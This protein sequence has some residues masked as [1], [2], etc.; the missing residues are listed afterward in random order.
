MPEIRLAGP[1]DFEGW[2]RAARH[3]A[4]RGVPPEA[5][6]WQ[7]PGSTADLFGAGEGEA[8]ADAGAP[9]PPRELRVPRRFVDLAESVICHRD[10][11][12]FGLLYRLLWRL[13]EQ[14]KLLDITTDD[15]VFRLEMMAKSVRR[16]RH[17]MT[18]FVRFKEVVTADGPAFL[19]WFEPEHHIEAL[20]APFFVDVRHCVSEDIPRAIAKL[21][22]HIRHYHFEDIAASRVHHHLVPGRG[23]IDFSGVIRAIEATGY[24]G[25][26]TVE[27]YPNIDDPDVAARGAIEFLKPLLTPATAA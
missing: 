20:A 22:P 6:V 9:G 14:P 2:R 5:V 16:D 10:P 21:A 23:A 7:A 24:D 4:E 19:A 1:D 13:Q 25:W 12:R 8:G 15:D 17:K 27:L 18:A 11:G 3:L 26:L